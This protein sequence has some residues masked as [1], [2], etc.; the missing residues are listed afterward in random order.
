M[1]SE[2]CKFSLIATCK[3]T[4]PFFVKLLFQILLEKFLFNELL[5]FF[6][7]FLDQS[8]LFPKNWVVLTQNVRDK[9]KFRLIRPFVT[10]ER[11]LSD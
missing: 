3:K 7:E 9:A 6:G 11:L 1:R 5:K 8:R 10:P 2:T 4:I